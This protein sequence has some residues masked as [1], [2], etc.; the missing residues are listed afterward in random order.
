MK[1][2]FTLV[3]LSIVLVIIGLLISGLLVG[4]SMVK[5]ARIKAQIKQIQQYDIALNNFKTLYK[6]IPGDC[7]NSLCP[8]TYSGDNNGVLNRVSPL[9]AASP[10]DRFT[11]EPYYFFID[12]STMGVLQELYQRIIQH[13]SCEKN[14]QFPEAAIGRGCL[15]AT[16]NAAGDIYWAF[17]YK[18]STTY[19]FTFSA[20][21]AEGNF[22]STEALALD[23]KLDDGNPATGNVAVTTSTAEANGSTGLPFTAETDSSTTCVYNS[24]YNVSVSDTNLCRLVIKA[25]LY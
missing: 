19:E 25:S 9:P 14:E 20:M 12:M 6:Q 11:W 18:S 8:K 10:P 23:S 1:K 16:G 4:Q 3:E 21:L 15:I 22:S 13:Y 17:T 24:V 7:S 2:G 5:S